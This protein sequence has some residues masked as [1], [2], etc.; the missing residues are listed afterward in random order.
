MSHLL[1]RELC[2]SQRLI[3]IRNSRSSITFLEGVRLASPLLLTL[4]RVMDSQQIQ[5]P[6]ITRE[7]RISMLKH[8]RQ[9][10]LSLRTMTQIKST[11][12][13]ALE[14]SCH[15]STP[16]ATALL[17]MVTSMTLRSKASKA[18]WMLTRSRSTSVGFSDLLTSPQC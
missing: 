15:S 7:K 1:Q 8:S 18:A 12:Y 5:T 4:R 9:L 14:V 11:P 3:S 2:L 17:L 16:C 10:E 13:T 6:F